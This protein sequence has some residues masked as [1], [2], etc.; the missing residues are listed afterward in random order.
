[1][2]NVANAC[3]LTEV[4]FGD[5]NGRHDLV[6]VEVSEGLGCGILV[7]EAIAR[8]EC[9]MAGEFGHIQMAEDG[10]LCNCGNHG[11]WETLASNR[12]A[13][14]FYE[15]TSGNK[16]RVTFSGLL[17]LANAQDEAPWQLWTG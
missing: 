10:P 15:E 5:R 14:H 16:G 11:C 3:A 8:G 13:I 9:G 4:W 12:S 1:M 7:N 6:V 2:G 17:R